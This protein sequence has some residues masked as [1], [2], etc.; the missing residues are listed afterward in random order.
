[1]RRICSTAPRGGLARPLALALLSLLLPPAARA[2][3]SDEIASVER[4]VKLLEDK[5]NLTR[6]EYLLYEDKGFT[7][8]RFESRLNDGQALML[9][10]DY[11]RAAIIFFELVEND[12]FRD[13]PGYTDAM[14]NLAEALFFN[15]NFVDARAY[16]QKVI[17]HPR[18]RAFRTRAISR[19]MQI[20]LNIRNYDQVDESMKA[21]QGEGGVSNEAQ[22]LYGKT[23]LERGRL[24]EALQVFGS[25]P[26]GGGYYFQ[27]RYLL[28]V[29]LIRQDKLEQALE[30]VTALSRLTPKT[31]AEKNVVE[32]AHMARGRLFY[33]LG[34][35]DQALD[36]YQAVP[37]TSKNF[38]RAL[39][40]ITMSYLQRSDRA[41]DPELRT[42]WL[43]EAARTVEIL[44]V[45]TPDSTLLPQAYLLQG[46][47]LEK[48]SR[49]E[50]AAQAFLKVGQNY[51]QVKQQ[52]DDLVTR[53]A[54]PVSYFNEV[55]G[56]NLDSF[57]LSSYLPPVAVKW[58]SG[59]D[60][61]SAAIGI[62][63]EIDTGKR[64]VR[65]S[66]ALL[67]KLDELVAN[68]RDRLALFPVLAE[69]TKRCLE[70]E[71]ARVV[72]ERTLA[73][74]EERVIEEHVSPAERK[75][76]QQARTERERLEGDLERLPVTQQDSDGRERRIKARVEELEQAVFQSSIT[77]K[78]MKAQLSAME[79]WIKQNESRLVGREE[80]VREFREEIR[81]GWATANQL[82]KE[83]EDLA[84][85]LATEK[86]R[87]GVSADVM[88]GEESLRERYRKALERERE[89]AARIHS[90]LGPEGSV[91]IDRINGLRQRLEK[92]GQD[93]A[94]VRRELSGRV[95]GEVEKL[96]AQA[97]QEA[98]NLADYEAA[99]QKLESESQNLA[100]EVA[101][102]ALEEVRKKFYDLVLES[103]VGILDVAWG[104]MQE[105]NRLINELTRKKNAEARQLQKEYKSVL[106]EVQ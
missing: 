23:L 55:A 4:Q 5:T 34:K 6:H 25:I 74:M 79:E 36:A 11:A 82:E 57:D 92:I 45:S 48:M 50:D 76:L 14:F 32:L 62:V 16:Y 29:V 87:I 101:Y 73:S 80:G 58:M 85:V 42:K 89:L 70:I 56:K 20:A 39:F 44:E 65:E 7:I 59:Q 99:L 47:I 9:L 98:K 1:L 78:G 96:K 71:N 12:R 66:R 3:L 67:A 49:F 41:E 38:D 102:R 52:L 37:H 60:E 24:E 26:P 88:A 19:L 93:T 64:F 8:D 104:R 95:D 21:L 2:D 10:A 13:Q 83:M 40:E 68:P 63:K 103:D 54:D 27:A 28:A 86:A 91:L 94:A 30:Q 43:Q 18:G 31:D 46:A 69:G 22:Y 84:N 72:V 75:D 51:N 105:K 17:E 97:R 15:R 61:M 100:G 106:E 33:D 90:R 81:R 77:I 35:E 53:H